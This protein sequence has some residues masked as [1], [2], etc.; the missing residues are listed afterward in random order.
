LNEIFFK[1]FF[2]KNFFSFLSFW[3]LPH[4]QLFAKQ[5]AGRGQQALTGQQQPIGPMACLQQQWMQ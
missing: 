1:I 4:L 3:V 2:L 5:Q